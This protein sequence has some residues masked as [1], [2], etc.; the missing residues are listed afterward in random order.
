MKKS[1][2]NKEIVCSIERAIDSIGDSWSLLI[3]RDLG[4][5]LSH[6]DEFQKNLGIAPGVLS[7]RLSGLVE[8]GLVSKVIYQTNPPRAKYVLTEGGRDF[9][10]VLAALMVWGNK[11]CS[12]KGID[13]EL[14][15]AKTYKKITPAL[16]DSGTGKPIDFS[17]SVY[18]G[19][20][21]NS[22]AKAKYLKDR[23]LPLVPAK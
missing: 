16:V 4:T 6:F 2:N 13:T 19:G 12:P 8:R 22:P 3:L 11:Y 15:D 7:K 14:V 20:P 9:L 17:T 18:V 23:G 1:E 21:G 5:G 10:P